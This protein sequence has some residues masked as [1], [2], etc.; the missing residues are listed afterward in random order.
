VSGWIYQAVRETNLQRRGKHQMRVLC[1]DRVGGGALAMPSGQK[2]KSNLS[3][4]ERSSTE[5]RCASFVHRLWNG[6]ETCQGSRWTP[7]DGTLDNSSTPSD[8][9][10]S[11]SP[12]KHMEGRHVGLDL[13]TFS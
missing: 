13:M 2:T 4:K 5:L 3:I 1:G 12:E 10:S 6:V 8:A 9:A 7:K 11:M